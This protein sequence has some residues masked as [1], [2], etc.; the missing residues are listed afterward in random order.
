MNKFKSQI[1]DWRRFDT[2]QGLVDSYEDTLE[3]HTAV[4]DDFFRRVLNDIE[5]ITLRRW[6]LANQHGYGETQF[7]WMWNLIAQE[8]PQDYKF[9]EIGVYRG[10]IPALM[11]LFSNRCGIKGSII[12]VTD[13]STIGFGDTHPGDPDFAQDIAK[14]FVYAKQSMD[15][16]RVIQGN[17]LNED[18]IYT[19]SLEAPFDLVYIDGGHE[20][21]EVVSDIK[22]YAEMIKDGGLLVIDDA[23][24][25]LNLPLEASQ[26]SP[27][28][29]IENRNEHYSKG[30]E[31]VTR[32]VEELVTSDP[33]F[34][35]LFAVGH[36]RVWRYN[37]T[38]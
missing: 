15:N 5:L 34:T 17:S 32:A 1:A 14:T 28:G 26:V 11:T 37:E 21:H 20:Y 23:S 2:F 10:Q 16:F 30:I 35:E 36:N 9:L 33:R 7:Y 19:T 22:H 24:C 29:S 6:I 12:G 25:D 8:L 27:I 13:L 4:R 31:S 18:V 38:I 3:F